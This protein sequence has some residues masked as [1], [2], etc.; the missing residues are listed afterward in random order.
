MNYLSNL[1]KG[2]TKAR[3]D[4]PLYAFLL[5]GVLLRLFHFFYNRSLW[6]DE[7]YL[8]ESLVKMN[9]SELVTTPLYYQ[10]KAPLGF[11]VLVKLVVDVFGNKEIY[12][13][14]IPL[15]SGMISLYL[16]IP[17]SK[18]FLNKWGAYLAMAIFCCSPA[19]VY[20]SVE[21]KQY[22]TELLGTM[23][24]LFIFIRYYTTRTYKNMLI[25]GVLGALVLW[26]SY[27]SIFVLSGIAIGLTIKNLIDRNLRFFF[28]NA[29]PFMMW[30]LSFAINYLFFTHKH[31]ESEWIVYWFKAYDNFMPLFPGSIADLLW[32]PKN[33]YRMLDYPLGLLWNFADFSNSQLVNVFLKTSFLSILCLATGIFMLFKERKVYLYVLFPPLILT[34]IASGLELYPLTERFWVFISPIFI[35]LIAMGF[36]YLS[37]AIRSNRLRLVLF[38]LLLTGP[39]VQSVIY[40]IQPEQFFVHKKSFQREALT[41][42]DTHIKPG[43]VV[44][45]YWNNL[46]G[47]RLYREMYGYHFPTVEGKDVRK[48]SA[49]FDAY[50]DNLKPDFD[51]VMQAKK[52][53]LV[54]NRSFLTDIGDKIDDPS[55]YYNS[56]NPTHQL[57]KQFN[58]LAKLKKAYIN[59]DIAIYVCE[60]K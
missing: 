60:P 15:V 13:R 52:I 56:I 46:P 33:L 2:I 4:W 19:L 29:V 28:L 12:L 32:F 51:R 7:V 41:Y 3:N 22:A 55:W 39:V 10:Q 27:A 47:Y 9:L 1:I 24:S 17:V 57:L 26:F 59:G 35:I 42:I 25:W 40:L 6:M 48:A 45:V 8:S 36:E 31:A 38:S 5:V 16:F 30:L 44:Y 58:K 14:L 49:N 20:H 43:E 23:V 11:L 18:Y 21:I 54:I 34:L 37:L 53:W 50:Y